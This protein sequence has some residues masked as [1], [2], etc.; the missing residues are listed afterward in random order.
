LD[1]LV[2]VK[3]WPNDVHLGYARAKEKTLEQLKTFENT[4]IE[5]H[6]KLIEEQGFFQEDLDF[7]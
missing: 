1:C 2:F 7:D 5:E 4:L 6:K 3:N